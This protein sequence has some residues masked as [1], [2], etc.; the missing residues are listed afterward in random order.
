MKCDA[1]CDS[2]CADCEAPIVYRIEHGRLLNP[3]GV[4]HFAVP[5]AKWWD[6]IVFT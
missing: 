2:S 1:Q 3:R 6:D 5:A 4:V